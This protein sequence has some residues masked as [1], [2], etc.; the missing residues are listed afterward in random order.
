M[1]GSYKSLLEEG[2]GFAGENGHDVLSGCS[3]GRFIHRQHALL[4]I[5]TAKGAIQTG[6]FA[7][8]S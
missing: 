3:D 6:V 8:T 1:T 7:S 5:R 2:A 4:F